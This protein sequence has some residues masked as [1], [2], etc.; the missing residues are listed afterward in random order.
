MSGRR[1]GRTLARETALVEDFNRRHPV[2]T[3][4]RFWKF[5]KKGTPSGEGPTLT[6]ARLL[7]G[8]T[9][10]VWIEGEPS[11]VALSHVEAAS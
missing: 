9:A 7:G 5:L 1:A 2:G 6:E 3:K 8:H 4:V 10:V 11:C